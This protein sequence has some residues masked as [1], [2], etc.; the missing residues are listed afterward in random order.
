VRALPVILLFAVTRAYA[1][2]FLPPRPIASAIAGPTDPHVAATF[3]NPAALGPLR[4][5]HVWA[6]GGAQLELGSIT[7]QVNGKSSSTGIDYAN[8]Q[9]FV[10]MTWDLRSDA[11]TIGLATYLPF[12]DL[13]TYR[14]SPAVRYH[15]TRHNL[16][17]YEQSLSGS[18]RVS[19]RFYV[20]ASATF[21]ETWLAPY[22]F[23]RDAAPAGGSAAVSLPSALCGGS[24]CGL[25]NPAAAQ[26]L[27]LQG[28]GWGIGFTVGV[29][30]RPVDRLWLALSYISHVFNVGRGSDLPIGQIA[31]VRLAGAGCGAGVVC[32]GDSTLTMALPDILYAGMRVEATTHIDVE[33]SARWVHYGARSQLDLNLQGG[34]LPGRPAA[35]ALPPELVIDRGLTDA[36]SVEASTRFKIG[37]QVRLS[38]SLVFETSAVEASAVSPAAI[39]ANKLDLALT[40]EWRPLPH[41]TLGAHVGGTAYLLGHVESRY[42]SAKLVACVDA[43][44]SLDAC[45]AVE[46]GQGLPSATGRYTLFTIHLGAAIGVDY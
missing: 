11:V 2:P 4:G 6:D 17:T 42:S 27:R 38:P 31:G 7:R 41:L 25:E 40:A 30:G 35:T 46:N 12:V 24:A 37:E 32:I 22:R 5:L 21:A 26:Y 45:G 10:G 33:A 36:F 9:G 43:Q 15:A 19:S 16:I 14:D 8:P 44:Y 28:F 18:F 39:D 13:T 34:S 1:Y 29:L 23:V 3:Y 20:G